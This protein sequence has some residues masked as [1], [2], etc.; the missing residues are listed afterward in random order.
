[1]L[2]NSINMLIMANDIKSLNVVLY[3]DCVNFS[4]EELLELFSN[5]VIGTNINFCIPKNV[6]C[7]LRF[8]MQNS[9]VQHFRNSANLILSHCVRLDWNIEDFYEAYSEHP[10]FVPYTCLFVFSKK[11]LKQKEFIT[12][13][14]QGLQHYVW[15]YE[16]DFKLIDRAKSPKYSMY[17][18]CKISFYK[19]PIDY[20]IAV[21]ENSDINNNLSYIKINKNCI[22]GQFDKGREA[23]IRD[24]D[25]YRFKNK[26]IKEYVSDRIPEKNLL[27]KLK[28]L[29]KFGSY[30][31]NMD[32]AFPEAIMYADGVTDKVMGLSMKKVNGLPLRSILEK[33]RDLYI[34]KK[35][36]YSNCVKK[37]L[38]VLLDLHCYGIYASDLSVNNIMFNKNTD[39]I[40]FVDCDSFQVLNIPG[41]GCFPDAKHKD[42]KCAR[43]E[44]TLRYPLHEDFALAVL[45][46]KIFVWNNLYITKKDSQYLIDWETDIFQLDYPGEYPEITFGRTTL[47]PRWN[48]LDEQLKIL[49]ADEFHFRKSFGIG[50]WIEALGFDK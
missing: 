49:F 36:K 47:E 45:L 11:S 19:T 5:R 20:D 37:I 38:T 34:V 26:C 23:A 27:E 25:D 22:H 48:A 24:C 4:K 10:P 32:I 12:H 15:C 31:P 46:Y 3:T 28:F 17:P 13:A 35:E 50:S 2:V 29:R 43:M 6:Y 42:I 1:M 9:K 7:E 14:Y 33:D 44:H 21:F 30:F 16:N 8:I 39:E 41:G 40:C 18:V